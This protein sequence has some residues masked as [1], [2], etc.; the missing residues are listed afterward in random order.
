MKATALHP[1]PKRR[2]AGA[3]PSLA[4]AVLLAAT[5][6][7]GASVPTL[8]DLRT[9]PGP[10]DRIEGESSEPGREGW[11]EIRSMG[12]N[13]DKGPHTTARR[14]G[15]P[16][17][18]D[19]VVV[20]ELDKASP[21]LQE[22]V[23]T[24]QVFPEMTVEIPLDGSH[25]GFVAQLSDVILTGYDIH[26]V[27]G[28]ERPIEE[29]S[30]YYNKIAFL[31]RPDAS[32]AGE[33]PLAALHFDLLFGTDDPERDDDGDGIDNFRDPDDDDDGVSDKYELENGL[34]PLVDDS[35]FDDDGDKKTNRE[36]WLAGTLAQDPNSRFNIHSIAFDREGHCTVKVPTI[37]G[38]RYKLRGSF[39]LAAGRWID[40]DEFE[41]PED[42]EP[43]MM[44]LA[45]PP[46]AAAQ[47]NRLFF[48]VEVS[49]P[50]Q[51]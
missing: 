51:P 8:I 28:D 11:I 25:P 12:F 42:A 24:G 50:G 27:Q 1:S 44:E 40:F 36:E 4:A 34:H 9:G 43:G 18:G 20:R 21:K 22:A 45:L 29:V 30:F 3:I 15:A 13:A 14:R 48:N 31:Y 41:T 17:L 26:I 32:G 38:R 16:I 5:G 7:C 39:D 35:E 19:I 47:F 33:P 49:L 46:G 6:A 2:G 23:L 10:D 37:G